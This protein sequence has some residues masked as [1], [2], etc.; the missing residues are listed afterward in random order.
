MVPRGGVAAISRLRSRSL[1]RPRNRTLP[2][3]STTGTQVVNRSTRMGSPSM[4]T[5]KMGGSQAAYFSSVAR[6]SSQRWQPAAYR[7]PVGRS[8]DRQPRVPAAPRPICVERDRADRR[9]QS[10]PR[11]SSHAA[12]TS[13]SPGR[14]GPRQPTGCGPC[15]RTGASPRAAPGRPATA[16]VSRG[17]G[18]RGPNRAPRCGEPRRNRP[19]PVRSPG[20]A[21]EHHPA[22]VQRYRSTSRRDSLRIR[23]LDTGAGDG[24]RKLRHPDG[25]AT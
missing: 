4:S 18:T 16:S 22:G 14:S 10:P 2:S 3:N 23:A 24:L 1:T 5:S 11:W 7:G 19:P 17:P 9:G 25:R 15:T 8:A 20:V 6:A 13:R 12:S 21:R